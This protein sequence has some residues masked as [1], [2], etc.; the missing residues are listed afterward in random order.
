[1][2]MWYLSNKEDIVVLHHQNKIQSYIERHTYHLLIPN[3]CYSPY[4]HLDQNHMQDMGEE[5]QHRYFVYIKNICLN[6]QNILCHKHS[7]GH[8]LL[9]N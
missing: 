4:T 3:L 7:Y 6:L 1:M 2:E 8:H 5:I 9:S